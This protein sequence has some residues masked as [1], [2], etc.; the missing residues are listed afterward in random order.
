[1]ANCIETLRTSIADFEEALALRR[2][3]PTVVLPERPWF[4][5]LKLDGAFQALVD[6]HNDE[7]RARSPGDA[8]LAA[9]HEIMARRSQVYGAVAAL[10]RHAMSHG[11]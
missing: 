6:G 7:L 10:C 4:S 5:Y 8:D 1:M 11:T 9:T 3:D 2:K